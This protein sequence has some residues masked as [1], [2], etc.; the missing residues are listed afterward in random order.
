MNLDNI[1]IK[2]FEYYKHEIEP[3]VFLFYLIDDTIISVNTSKENLAHLLGVNKSSFIEISSQRAIEIY[4]NIQKGKIK[5][6]FDLIDKER[7]KRNEL[8]LD[9]LFVYRKNINFIKLFN[10]L[11]D[12]INLRI[13]R[14]QPGDYFDADYIHLFKDNLGTGYISI[15]GSENTDMHYFNSILYETNKSEIYKGIQLK[16][17]KIERIEKKL[18][19]INKYSLVRSK[20]RTIYN[21]ENKHKIKSIKLD[22]KKIKNRV[23]QKLLYKLEIKIGQY[24][25]N[26][27]QIYKDG[28]CIENHYEKISTS[29]TVEEIVDEINKRYKN[30]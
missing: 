27:V 26:S 11:I 2:N 29:K 7:Y 18:F 10:S 15:I 6:I 1:I 5:S 23:N 28:K 19:D 21:N 12:N 3:Y 30:I 16:I 9:E 24:G 13:Y 8:S 25:K 14:K 17:K 20:R 22:Y 4:E